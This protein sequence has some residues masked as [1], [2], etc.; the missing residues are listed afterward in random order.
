M[1]YAASLP[2]L[3]CTKSTPSTTFGSPSSAYNALSLNNTR[4]MAANWRQTVVPVVTP[5][6]PVTGAA[7]IGVFVAL[8]VLAGLLR[9]RKTARKG[10]NA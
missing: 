2:L 6:V 3:D 9:R 7:G 10:E 1:R 8:L 5:E 4:V